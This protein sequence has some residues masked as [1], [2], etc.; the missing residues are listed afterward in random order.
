MYYSSLA[1]PWE[2]YINQPVNSAR[3]KGHHRDKAIKQTDKMRVSKN[4][5][6]IYMRKFKY[7]M[8]HSKYF[9]KPTLDTYNTCVYNIKYKT[10]IKTLQYIWKT[11]TYN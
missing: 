6:Y 10:L 3:Q 1:L 5:E 7:F 4:T 8:K 9:Y 2:V 11:T